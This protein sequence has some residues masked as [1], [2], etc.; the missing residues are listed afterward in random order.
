MK[1]TGLS[2]SA[3]SSKVVFY[4]IKQ[5]CENVLL[6]AE[7]VK[8]HTS[9][10]DVMLVSANRQI[11]FLVENDAIDEAM[12]VPEH[13]SSN[14]QLARTFHIA[15][16]LKTMFGLGYK[17]LIYMDCQTL[18]CSSIE[19]IFD[20][21]DYF[22]FMG[23]HSPDRYSSD[24]VHDVPNAFPE[25][26]IGM[27][28]MRNTNSVRMMWSEMCEWYTLHE[29][30]YGDND[31]GVLRD[32]LWKYT[33]CD[34]GPRLYVLPPEYSFRLGYSYFVNGEVKVIHGNDAN[35][36]KVKGLRLTND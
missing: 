3:R 11:T 4:V 27:N 25:I 6:S 29:E 12:I 34:D 15:T 13:G 10:V 23:V 14:W 21:L 35:C 2:G 32:I 33:W 30:I 18:M 7:S 8:N 31:Q 16:A 28:P 19:D 26:G 5:E 36:R 1:D 24:T 9:D 20:M 17:K 22:E